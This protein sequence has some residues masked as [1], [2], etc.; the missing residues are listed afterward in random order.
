MIVSDQ[1]VKMLDVELRR[2]IGFHVSNLAVELTEALVA[3]GFLVD[4]D[5]GILG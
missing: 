3:A 2:R 5:D 1:V 4:Q